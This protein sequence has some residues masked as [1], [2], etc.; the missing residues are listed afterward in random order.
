MSNLIILVNI[1]LL[2]SIT[3]SSVISS[4]VLDNYKHQETSELKKSIIQLIRNSTINFLNKVVDDEQESISKECYDNLMKAYGDQ[5]KDE[6]IYKL[7]QDS[8]KGKNDLGSYNDCLNV[9]YEEVIDQDVKSSILS[10]LTYVIININKNKLR[11]ANIKKENLNYLFGICIIKYCKETEYI[12]LFVDISKGITKDHINITVDDTDAVDINNY[13]SS[14]NFSLSYILLLIPFFIFTI[15]ILFV[16]FPSIP[17]LILKFFEMCF[18]KEDNNS[19]SIIDQSDEYNNSSEE[20]KIKINLNNKRKY[21]KNSDES[22]EIVHKTYIFTKNYVKNNYYKKIYK[23]FS[24]YNSIENA[25]S[26]NNSKYTTTGISHL[27]GLRAISIIGLVYG[28]VFYIL[29]NSPLKLQTEDTMDLLYN[30]FNFY[31]INLGLRFIPS[32]L[33]SISGYLLVYKFYFYIDNYLINKTNSITQH[34]TPLSPEES[35]D[36]ENNLTNNDLDSKEEDANNIKSLLNNTIDNEVIMNDVFNS[37]SSFLLPDK[38]ANE[39]LSYILL[40]KFLFFYLHRYIIFIFNI[41]FFYFSLFYVIGYITGD[42]APMWA[43]FKAN[44][45][46]PY[47]NKIFSTIFLIDTFKEWEFWCPFSII[48]NEFIYFVFFTILLF[49]CYKYKLRLDIIIKVMFFFFLGFK[50]L[51]FWGIAFYYNNDNWDIYNTLFIFGDVNAYMLNYPLYNV[52]FYIIGIFYGLLNYVYQKGINEE[53]IANSGFFYLYYFLDI[54][55]AS[56]KNK[57]LKTWFALIITAFIMIFCP[58]LFIILFKLSSNKETFFK[59]IYYN[60]FMLIDCEIF[61]A[62]VLYSLFYISLA[63]GR[64]VYFLSHNYWNLFS[65]MYYMTLINMGPVI[66]FVF[67]QSESRINLEYFN[68]FFFFLFSF[69]LLIIIN[70][71]MYIF[72]ELPIKKL[73]HIVNKCIFDKVLLLEYN[74]SIY[75]NKIY[76]NKENNN[77]NKLVMYERENTVNSNLSKLS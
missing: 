69:V 29:F 45:I 44:I 5:N 15:W 28:Y 37:S 55:D 60:F 21:S 57:N 72:E 50:F 54:I 10:D 20:K 39:K 61:I 1:L 77:E 53:S 58:L 3:I 41:C 56:N 32:L 71:I 4:N 7:I 73:S 42:I 67:Y 24:I 65:K 14:P 40:F 16:L 38:I 12:N 19:K 27:R 70:I 9:N 8:A 34:S 63:S 11:K 33:Y 30:N 26:I 48:V 2:Y 75:N 22:N 66:F 46:N 74:T 31:F 25:F 51:T 76:N 6:Y 59:N 47:K 17:V 23:A 18:K 49:I 62:F 64:L 35:D 36:N 68:L 13:K 52:T 43:Y